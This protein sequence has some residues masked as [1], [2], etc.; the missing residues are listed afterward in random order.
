MSNKDKL[1]IFFKFLPTRATY[2]TITFL[3][4][5]GNRKLNSP[6]D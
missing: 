5:R 3:S 6:N 1:E 4:F 2:Q